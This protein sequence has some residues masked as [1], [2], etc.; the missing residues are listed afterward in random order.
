MKARRVVAGVLSL[1]LGVVLLW[2][3]FVWW[4]VSGISVMDT[5]DGAPAGPLHGYGVL[6]VLVLG[7]AGSLFWGIRRLGRPRTQKGR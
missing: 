7:A 2:A 6:T 3:A 5:A 4:V 1:V